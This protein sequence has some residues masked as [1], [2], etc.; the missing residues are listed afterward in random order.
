MVPRKQILRIFIFCTLLTLVIG[1]SHTWIIGRLS[2]ILPHHHCNYDPN[3]TIACYESSFVASLFVAS[4]F[5][6]SLLGM[7]I[8]TIY[9]LVL[10]LRR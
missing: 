8:T 5:L 2:P 3:L 10:W 1:L 6:V 4:I 7:I 9:S